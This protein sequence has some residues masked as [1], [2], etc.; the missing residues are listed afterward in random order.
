MSAVPVPSKIMVSPVTGTVVPLQ[1]AAVENELSLVE[2]QR[3]I[4]T[5]TPFD[6]YPR[7][8]P[9]P[10]VC[11]AS[12][13]CPASEHNASSNFA[14]SCLPSVTELFDSFARSPSLIFRNLGRSFASAA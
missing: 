5:E 4:A 1:F 2:I 3:L 9:Q 6:P 13:P 8:H 10:S 7:L 11:G 12:A 14:A